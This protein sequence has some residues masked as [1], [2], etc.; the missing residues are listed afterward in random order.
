M[1]SGA[2]G[3]ILVFSTVDRKSFEAIE[4]WKQKV[5]DEC[6]NICMVLIQNKID[7]LDERVIEAYV[8]NGNKIIV[9]V[10]KRKH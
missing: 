5:E 8:N 7:L 10:M 6:G 3:C 9:I 2:G 4:Y 1:S